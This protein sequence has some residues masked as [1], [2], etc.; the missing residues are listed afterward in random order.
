MINVW[1]GCNLMY[2]QTCT[3][4]CMCAILNLAY[5]DVQ[6]SNVFVQIADQEKING[7]CFYVSTLCN[8][9][10]ITNITVCVCFTSK[11]WIWGQWVSNLTVCS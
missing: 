11:S 6:Y 5:C 7:G 8:M 2:N 10:F 1:L 4:K 3:Q 9:K